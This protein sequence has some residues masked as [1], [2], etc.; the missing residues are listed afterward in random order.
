MGLGVGDQTM[1]I[2][3]GIIEIDIGIGVGIMVVKN[4][5]DWDFLEKL[6]ENLM[7]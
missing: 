3:G 5:W 1:E 6:S 4:F 2:I 7:I